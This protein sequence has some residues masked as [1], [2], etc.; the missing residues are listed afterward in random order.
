MER[1]LNVLVNP[2]VN[3]TSYIA[4]L[5]KGV[6]KVNVIKH[7]KG[8]PVN[9]DIDIVLFTGGEDVDPKFYNYLKNKKTRSNMDRDIFEKDMFNRYSVSSGQVNKNVL[10]LGICR[11]SQFLTVMSGG[12]LIQHVNNHTSSHPITISSDY[13]DA[14]VDIRAQLDDWFRATSARGE[15]V[16]ND[17]LRAEE[18]RLRAL[19]KGEI[20]VIATST[21]HQML[22]PFHLA[23][24]AYEMIAHSTYFRSDVYELEHEESQLNTNN[25]KNFLEPE[26]VYYPKI[27]ALAIQG[28]PEMDSATEEF[29]AMCIKI[30]NKKLGK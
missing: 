24:D 17:Q 9:Q 18:R 23:K 3:N 1:T 28:H 10:L 5:E 8:D 29:T 21:H 2:A 15:R 19:Y 20:E 30:I 7:S 16:G 13:N 25:I 11:G 6:G 27:N 26:I 14:K 22:M 12:S 4:F